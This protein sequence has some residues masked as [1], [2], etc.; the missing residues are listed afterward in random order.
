[1]RLYIDCEWNE[2]GGELISMALVAD[3]GFEWYEVLNCDNPGSWVSKNVMPKLNK[4]PV[5]LAEMRK[6][7]HHF[8]S[9]FD[10]VH[11]IADWP[12]DIAH[13][14]KLLI[15]GPGER[16]NTPPLSMEVKRD[17]NAQSNLP[18]N[19]LEDAKAIMLA[20]NR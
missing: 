13:F 7:L 4:A 12:E 3:G 18:H 10:S 14:C 1:M 19:A 6:S 16:I 5:S 9:Q 15:T 2:Y 8:L 17:L 20:D 11:L